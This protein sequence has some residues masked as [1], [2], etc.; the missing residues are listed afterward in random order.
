MPI[1]T[2]W[3]YDTVLLSGAS[4]WL[5]R[6][7]ADV[8]ARGMPDDPRFAGAFSG[9]IRCL[10]QPGQD[11]RALRE[12]G[13]GV[14]V[15]VGD[16]RDPAACEAFC[17]A[18][19]GAILLH[20]AGVI[21]PRRVRE[22]Y[23]VNVD[24]SRNLLAAAARSRVRRAVVVSSNSPCGC[25]PRRDHRFDERSPYHPYMN[26]GR[27]K[28]MMEE[29][30]RAL[31]AEGRIET[32]VLRP[33]WFYG[34]FQPPRQ[35]LFFDMIRRGKAPLV[36]DGENPR[37]M[38]YIDN[39]CQGVLLA[40]AAPQARGQTYWIADARPYTMNEVID[41]VERLLDEEFGVACAHRRLRLPGLASEVAWLADKA[42]QS[43]GFYQQ[44]IHVLSVMN[45]TIAC[46]IDKAVTDLGYA[47]RVELVEGMRRS[48]CWLKDTM[49]DLPMWRAKL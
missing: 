36:G 23:E 22:F 20:T 17:A 15:H 10:I 8:L 47:P 38:C 46:T 44:K 33:P 19:D 24:G 45:K 14:E 7:L 13:P 27:S 39:L 29:N 4:G 18:A 42:L 35:T 25:N 11:G 37:S 40:A 6:R 31:A 34:P 49:P 43:A 1:E 30:V 9:R 32:V 3:S 5:G 28:M 26:Y 16:L 21:H 41:S 48:L 2:S 12:L